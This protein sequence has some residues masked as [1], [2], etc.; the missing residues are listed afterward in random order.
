MDSAESVSKRPS[1]FC[2]EAQMFGL[3]EIKGFLKGFEMY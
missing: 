2:K 3:E 1:P